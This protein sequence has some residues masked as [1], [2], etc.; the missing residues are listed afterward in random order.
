VSVTTPEVDKCP[1][2]G[3]SLQL[4]DNDRCVYCHAHVT[5]EAHAAMILGR[6]WNGDAAEPAN[7]ILDVMY[8]LWSIDAI[9]KKVIGQSLL[10]SVRDLL[11]AVEAA[12]LAA[13][14]KRRHPDGVVHSFN[15][16]V[17]W[18]SPQELWLVDLGKDLVY[19]LTDG[20]R[21]NLP[22]FAPHLE[23]ELGSH[24]YRRAIERA[25]PGPEQFQGLRSA[26]PHFE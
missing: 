23:R 17:D 18:Y 10:P 11:A 6:D 16:D 1:E 22:G 8:E 2:C 7:S 5:I 12:G 15:F 13:S 24:T 4:D 9:Q 19:W 25:G 26:I 3:A 21:A 20:G 14:G